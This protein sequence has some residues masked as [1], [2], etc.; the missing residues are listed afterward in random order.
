MSDDE[1]R[2][3][4]RYLYS[5]EILIG[6][7]RNEALRARLTPNQLR[8]R[9]GRPAGSSTITRPELEAVVDRLR[10][11]NRDVSQRVVAI[12]YPCGL[13]TLK[14]WLRLHPGAWAELTARGRHK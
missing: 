3:A 4:E 10:I 7:Q 13:T 1:E 9:L 8:P 5:R 11:N 6:R 2:M 12:E 14:D